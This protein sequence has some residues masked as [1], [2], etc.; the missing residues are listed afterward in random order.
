MSLILFLACFLVSFN[1]T[2]PPLYQRIAV[3][4]VVDFGKSC[5]AAVNPAVRTAAITMF[6]L[7]RMYVPAL[8]TLL[9]GEK[10]GIMATL[11]EKFAEVEGKPVPTAT[12]SERSGGTKGSAPGTSYRGFQLP[13]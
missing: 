10:P 6:A 13:R 11:I 12:V 9:E 3:K 7:L 5:L 4:P 8:P 1:L 2:L